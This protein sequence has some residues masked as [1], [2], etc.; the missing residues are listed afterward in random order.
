MNYRISGRAQD[1]IREVHAYTVDRWNDAQAEAYITGLFDHFQLV[2]DGKAFWRLIPADF[3]VEGHFSRY[4]RHYA[5]WRR[6]SD[7]VLGVVTVLHE[8]MHQLE[9]FAEDSA[10]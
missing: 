9:R 2:A 4:Q 3:G 10:P 8:R 6:L 7:D 5:Y 1:R